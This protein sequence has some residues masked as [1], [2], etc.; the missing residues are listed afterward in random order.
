M[1]QQLYL[2]RQLQHLRESEPE[3]FYRVNHPLFS[4]ALLL[5]FLQQ[6]DLQ[7]QDVTGLMQRI[8]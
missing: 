2:L 8:L 6:Q 4:F 3:W 7:I 5:Q 1:S